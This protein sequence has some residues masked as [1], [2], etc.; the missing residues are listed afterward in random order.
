[1]S[2]DANADTA[3]KPRQSDWRSDFWL[4]T[5]HILP[6]LIGCI[7]FALIY[8]TN[9]ALKGLSGL[10]TGLMSLMVFAGSSQFVAVE[11][12][13]DPV[14]LLL[15]VATTAMVN[16]RHLLMSA[17]LAPAMGRFGPLRA[18]GALFFLAD[19]IW[20]IAMRRATEGRFTPAY[21]A[22]LFASFYLSWAF[23]G[24]VGHRLGAAVIDP[25]RFG[26]DFAFTAV[27]IVILRG[28]WRG[29]AS[30]APLLASV[31]VAILAYAF[32]PGVWYIFLGGLS[33]I[34]AGGLMALRRPE[35]AHAA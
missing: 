28:L 17:A 7:P 29:K 30:L 8:G 26:F 23:W 12:W 13:R 27:F 22:G 14:P 32:L 1:M 33:G 21:Y 25:A 18:Y 4:G 6:L 11:I 20:A 2:I 19:E 15:I 10:E 5:L 31:S 3:A 35:G 16:I 9:A 34:L 24:V